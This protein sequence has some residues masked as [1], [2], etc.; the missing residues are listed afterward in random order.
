[1]GAYSD[2]RQDVLAELV[3]KGEPFSTNEFTERVKVTKKT[4]LKDLQRYREENPSSLLYCTD[5][6][7][8]IPV[9]K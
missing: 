8:W 5:S 4:A 3:S 6:F 2:I 1:M 7:K 9:K